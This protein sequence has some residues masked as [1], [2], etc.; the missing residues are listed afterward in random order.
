MIPIKSIEQ[1]QIGIRT[2]STGPKINLGS[3]LSRSR[4]LGDKYVPRPSKPQR[5]SLQR[6]L[7][8]RRISESFQTV[9]RKRSEDA[10]TQQSPSSCLETG[11][12]EDASLDLD[13][14]GG[15]QKWKQLKKLGRDDLRQRRIQLQEMGVNRRVSIHHQSGWVSYLCNA[16]GLS[17][18]TCVITKLVS[19]F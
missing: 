17:G 18:F 7:L 6:E 5:T 2:Q 14:S 15:K 3:S 4:V 19:C 16:I 1:K 10:T 8:A 12:G 11:R 9:Q 13:Q